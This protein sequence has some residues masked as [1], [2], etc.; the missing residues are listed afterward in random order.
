[1][2]RS[3]FREEQIIAILKEPEAGM[4]TA[5][6]CRRHGVSPGAQTCSRTFLSPY[7]MRLANHPDVGFWHIAKFF[8]NAKLGRYQG[9]AEIEQAAFHS[10]WLKRPTRSHSWRSARGVR[11]PRRYALRGR[12]GPGR[13]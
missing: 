5:D 4:A 7:L 11:H 6:M 10:I 9:K 12:G 1:M 8:C 3:R 2:K 13:V